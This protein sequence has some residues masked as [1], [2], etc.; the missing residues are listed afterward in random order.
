ML[1]QQELLVSELMGIMLSILGSKD[2]RLKKVSLLC[3]MCY[4]SHSSY[5]LCVIEQI[6]KLRS[7]LSSKEHL[8]EFRR[9]IRLPLDPATVV[10]GIVAE[11][12]SMFKSALTPAKLGFKTTTNSI[13]WVSKA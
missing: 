13:Y 2:D 5:V 3:A 7:T 10:T 11:N 12:A 9:P 1:T 6:E 8:L 4:R